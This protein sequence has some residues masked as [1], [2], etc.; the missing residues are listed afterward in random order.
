MRKLL[1]LLLIGAIAFIAYSLGAKAGHGRYREIK[2]GLE[3]IWNDPRVKKGR[4]RAVKQA[5]KTAQ[6]LAKSAQKIGR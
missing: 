6:S 3:A 2:A 5:D 1:T 4:K